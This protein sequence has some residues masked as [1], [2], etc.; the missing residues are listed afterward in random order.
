MDQ[1]MYLIKSPTA[2][3]FVAIGR[4]PE[5]SGP[6][7]AAEA[8]LRLRGTEEVEAVRIALGDVGL[9]PKRVQPVDFL[10]ERAEG[11]AMGRIAARGAALHSGSRRPV[12]DEHGPHG[13]AATL[14]GLAI[15]APRLVEQIETGTQW[16]D[17]EDAAEHAQGVAE[18]VIAV[19][20]LD[21]AS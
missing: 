13:L 6:G 3:V 15:D 18:E 17:L 1:G 16:V 2:V 8:W 20:P 11:W 14:L 19:L 5:G 9:L 12:P 7:L 21:G 4:E 10:L